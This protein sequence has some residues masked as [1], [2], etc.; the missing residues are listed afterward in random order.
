VS[1]EIVA[2]PVSAK[3][4]LLTVRLPEAFPGAVGANL[5][6][7][8]RF[9]LA[10]RVTG[11]VGTPFNGNTAPLELILLIVAG[12]EPG[13]TTW[14]WTALELLTSVAG[15]VM[16]PPGSTGTAVCPEVE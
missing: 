12:V 6:V 3:L 14:N 9:P 2:E 7:N 10:G 13:L 1:G 15:K 4:L 16:V 5:T 11:R 8:D